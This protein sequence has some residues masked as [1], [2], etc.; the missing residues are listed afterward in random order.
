[1]MGVKFAGGVEIMVEYAG[2]LVLS[3]EVLG[4]HLSP[5]IRLLSSDVYI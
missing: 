5:G 4:R 2:R 3:S 1:M